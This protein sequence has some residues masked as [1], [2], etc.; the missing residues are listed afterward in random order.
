MSLINLQLENEQIIDEYFENLC[1][2][3]YTIPFLK[4]G[5][6]NADT[7]L[8][9]L[10]IDRYSTKRNN[11]YPKSKRGSSYLS[12]YIRHGLLSLKDVWNAVDSF[13]YKDKSKF[14]DQDF[15]Q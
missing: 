9:Q 10:N 11:V 7:A 1:C 14:R 2:D 12:P 5:Q 3:N 6:S 8:N 13:E 15:W 4:G